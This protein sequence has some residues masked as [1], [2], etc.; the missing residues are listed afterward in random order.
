MVAPQ[1][2]DYATERANRLTSCPEIERLNIAIVATH[3]KL[4]CISM[5]YFLDGKRN[6]R[7]RCF[8]SGHPRANG[9]SVICAGHLEGGFNV[10][11]WC[12]GRHPKVL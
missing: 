10:T 1:F 11:N 8:L 3:M 6:L 4:N 7:I 12:N 5:Q 9:V 2:Q